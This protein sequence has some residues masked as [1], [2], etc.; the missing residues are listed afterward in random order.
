ML[1]REEAWELLASKG[2]ERHMLHHALETEAVMRGLARR[3][4]QDEDVWGLTGLLHD[5]DFHETKDIPDEHALRAATWLADAL[6]GEALQAI[7]AHNGERNGIMPAAQF[8]Y[9]LRCAETVTGLV[10]AA[11]LVR[12]TKL[13]GLGAKSLKKKMKDKAFAAAVNR[14]II[15]ECERVGV[16]LDDFLNDAV[17]SIAEIADQVD[18][19]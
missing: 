10:S 3:L 18:L 11:A 7:R 19:K 14:E 4:E 16:S 13:D 15:R 8:D 17:A 12:P 6:P 9:A 5:L 1:T 2:Q